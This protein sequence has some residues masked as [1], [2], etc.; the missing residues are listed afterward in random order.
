MPSISSSIYTNI[1]YNHLC[2]HEWHHR[3]SQTRHYQTK[4]FLRRWIHIFRGGRPQTLRHCLRELANLS[5]QRMR[6]WHWLGHC[7]RR[8]CRFASQIL[9]HT[10][11]ARLHSTQ[12]HGLYLC[13]RDMPFFGKS[14]RV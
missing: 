12:L 5:Q 7:V 8:N 6:A 14:T 11:L 10:I 3:V 2:L 13:G 4:P 9:G 1:R